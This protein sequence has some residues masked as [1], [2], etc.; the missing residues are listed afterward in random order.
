VLLPKDVSRQLAILTACHF[1]VHFER[2]QRLAAPFPSHSPRE[3]PRPSAAIAADASIPSS[4]AKPAGSGGEAGRQDFV[5]ALLPSGS[6]SP[7]SWRLQPSYLTACRARRCVLAAQRR[8]GKS[9]IAAGMSSSVSSG[10]DTRPSAAGAWPDSSALISSISRVPL[11]RNVRQVTGQHQLAGR[12]PS[13]KLAMSR[14]SQLL[15]RC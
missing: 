6:P 11:E 13:P 15:G 3:H 2:Y 8:R 10:T 7:V 14:I 1:P 9:Q 12:G 4:P 5:A